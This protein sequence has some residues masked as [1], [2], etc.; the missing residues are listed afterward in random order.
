MIR[1]RIFHVEKSGCCSKR[2]IGLRRR[3]ALR[4]AAAYALET[5]NAAMCCPG[6][7]AE[8]KLGG[9]APEIGLGEL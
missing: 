9:L 8:G 4:G 5:G 3:S 6:G 7:V 2:T 1:D